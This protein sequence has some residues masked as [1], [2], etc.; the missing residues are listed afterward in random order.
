MF[1]CIKGLSPSQKSLLGTLTK[2]I[3]VMPATIAINE[4]SFS[5]LHN[6]KSYLR[7]T[8]A[9]ERLNH[10]MILSVH[11]NLTDSLNLVE[12][13]NEF[14]SVSEHRMTLFGIFSTNDM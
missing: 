1:T 10:L 11:K 13:A 2:L 14:V 4:C 9:Q 6:V 12:V 5:A 8:V 7:S 3:M